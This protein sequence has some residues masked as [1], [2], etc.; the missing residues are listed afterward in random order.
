MKN[1]KNNIPQGLLSVA[2]AITLATL[3]APMMAGSASAATVSFQ[4]GTAATDSVDVDYD[5][6][7]SDIAGGVQI[8]VNQAA[9]SP[10]SADI[11]GLFFNLQPGNASNFGITSASQFTKLAGDAI[12]QVCFNTTSCG[13]GNNING[14]TMPSSF[15]IGM[16]LGS[17][18]SSGGLVKFSSFTIASA[19]L[20]TANFLN[21]AFAVRAQTAGSNPATGGSGS[22]KELGFAPSTVDTI[23]PP[24]PGGGGTGAVPEPLTMLGAGAA[25]A[26]GSYF[27]KRANKN[28]NKA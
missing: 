6:K 13:S 27:K 17:T 9:T 19:N 1:I 11:L 24:P 2:G 23:T 25:V 22:V 26:F 10:N 12:T 28:S 8:D 16:K 18:G 3:S 20:T 15:D 4:V 21:Q 5:V 7:I 14:G